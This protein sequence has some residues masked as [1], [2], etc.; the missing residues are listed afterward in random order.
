MNKDLVTIKKN[1]TFV[2]ANKKENT[3]G[4]LVQPG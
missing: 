2:A 1:T 3:L 4:A